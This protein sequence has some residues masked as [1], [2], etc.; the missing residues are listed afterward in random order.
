MRFPF[1]DSIGQPGT[2]G[3]LSD[4]KGF[5]P[6]VPTG[7]SYWEIGTGPAAT[8]ATDDYR[9][10]T[11]AIDE[12]TRQNS[13]I[14]IVNP[15][16]AVKEWRDSN[17]NNIQK[18]WVER[19]KGKGEWGD[20][21]LLDGTIIVDWI[22]RFPDVGMWLAE[23]IIGLPIHHIETVD[24]HWEL[25]Q[26]YGGPNPLTPGL[27]LGNRRNAIQRLRELFH[28]EAKEIRLHTIFPHQVADFVCAFIASLEENQR[29]VEARR[30]LIVSD[31]STWSSVCEI[32]KGANL[33]LV[34]TPAL[35]MSGESG[36]RRIQKARV[37]GH[38]V[39]Y[40]APLGG[41]DEDLTHRLQNPRNSDIY[42]SLKSSGITHQRARAIA[43]K[44]DRNI[45][46]ALKL[47]HGESFVPEWAEGQNSDVL[48]FAFLAG[49]WDHNSLA[50]R[51]ILQELTGQDYTDWCR[52]LRMIIDVH[53]PP[54][55][56][57]NGRWKFVSR[58]DGWNA[59]GRL[60]D[61]DHLR[62][63]HRAVTMALFVD[64][65]QIEIEEEEY[66]QFIQ[67][68]KHFN[69]SPELQRGLVELLALMGSYPNVPTSM[70]REQIEQFVTRTV[71][72]VLRG[73]EN[74]KW[75]MANSALPLLAEASPTGFLDV[76]EGAVEH[77]GVLFGE[78]DLLGE[79]G[80]HRTALPHGLV[81]AIQALAWSQEFLSRACVLLGKLLELELLKDEDGFSLRA[82]SQILFPLLP[83]SEGSL[84]DRLDTVRRV[85]RETPNTGWR[86][87]LS[88]FP[89]KGGFVTTN[90]RPI[91]RETVSDDW[92]P[93]VV[94][95]R[96]LIYQLESLSEL[97]VDLVGEDYEK[98]SDNQFVELLPDLSPTAFQKALDVLSSPLVIDRPDHQR[99][100]LWKHLTALY[101][102]H[103]EFVDAAWSL[104]EDAVFE[105]GR[106]A[107]AIRPKDPKLI[108]GLVFS[109]DA[110]LLVNDSEWDSDD[111][112]MYD[113]AKELLRQQILK[114]TLDN[115]GLN[116][117]IELAKDVGEP[118]AFGHHLAE[119]ASSESDRLLLP[120]W[121]TSPSGNNCTEIIRAYV[122]RRHRLQGWKWLDA[123]DRSNWTPAQIGTL[124]GWMPF[125]SET[126]KRVERWLGR[127]EKEYW[128]RTHTFVSKEHETDYDVALKKLIHF[129]RR[130]VAI[131]LLAGLCFHE[132][133]FD[134]RLAY[135]VLLLEIP[136]SQTMEQETIYNIDMIIK[137]LQSCQGLLTE[138]LLEVEWKYLSLLGIHSSFSPVTIE[139]QLSSDPAYFCEI[140]GIHHRLR[141]I[142]RAD[143]SKY[144]SLEVDIHNNIHEMV[145]RHW[146]M[147]PGMFP[148]GEFRANV[149]EEWIEKVYRLCGKTKLIETAQ[150]FIGEVLFHAP[151]DPDG[152]WIHRSIAKALNDTRAQIMRHA[153]F[154]ATRN[155]RGVYRVEGTG[156]QERELAEKF[157]V[158]AEQLRDAGFNRLAST[159]QSVSRSYDIDS[160]YAIRRDEIEN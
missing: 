41:V 92:E 32:Y 113:Q 122:Q 123:T 7:D 87:L 151:P 19:K 45:D 18:A 44:C 26:S 125:E 8:K 143:L 97:V 80:T 147:L 116:G 51:E 150:D 77:G 76:V 88:L 4:D 109:N 102:R 124:L 14:V 20:V 158:R 156:A 89:H 82:L 137:A 68:N 103:A 133:P 128:E 35:Y 43:D 81:W 57:L 37:C 74:I 121:L 160:E 117:A 141:S 115:H 131:G 34:A 130:D 50:D 9:K 17:G 31:P 65:F 155:S 71:R 1:G 119:F 69:I 66:S 127:D 24:R 54:V 144:D 108:L 142:P 146:R 94:S 58:F 135:Q 47:L 145:D 114:E 72:E 67:E 105:L 91:W 53:N 153:Y 120:E 139:R 101:R 52:Q 12:A 11:E 22:Q 118:G 55:V 106:V 63:L 36:L 104:D 56:E 126:W 86:L 21:A 49:A 112:K 64:K 25:L 100:T 134:T 152:L 38:S 23:R 98:L 16:S 149:F 2:D 132:R 28:G 3:F 73:S 159:L 15:R 59:L 138:E 95:Q 70:S 154:I 48:T 6:F 40:D 140:T 79:K 90:Y 46:Q 13:I 83:Q 30:T 84:H 33:V 78:S 129:R 39:I 60:L 42:E 5:L 111:W 75:I 157:R 62:R 10:R 27:F 85:L 110:R 99:L 107:K 136:Q 93:K 29:I 61:E 148:D 96:E